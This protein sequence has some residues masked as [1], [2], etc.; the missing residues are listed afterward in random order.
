MPIKSKLM[1]RLKETY[2]DKKWE[3]IYYAMENKLKHRDKKSLQ[4]QINKAK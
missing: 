4:E 2:W 1:K 3:D